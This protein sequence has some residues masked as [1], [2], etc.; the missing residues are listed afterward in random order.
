MIHEIVNHFAKA[1]PIVVRD[2]L[3]ICVSA[4]AEEEFGI[5]GRECR[6][7]GRT[8]CLE[9]ILLFL[10]DRAVGLQH[11]HCRSFFE[12]VFSEQE[13]DHAVF[14][15]FDHF[16]SKINLNGPI[17]NTITPP[18]KHTNKNWVELLLKQLKIIGS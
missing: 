18:L 1:V 16:L 6:L 17:L 14:K 2:T 15:Y 7:K 5:Q 9:T 8:E 10:D 11:F 13:H 4:F 12:K 3:L